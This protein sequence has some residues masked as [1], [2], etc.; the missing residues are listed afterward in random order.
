MKELWQDEIDHAEP[1]PSDF[2]TKKEWNEFCKVY[3]SKSS[4]RHKQK[5]EADKQ[6]AVDLEIQRIADRCGVPMSIDRL[7]DNADSWL[8]DEPWR[9]W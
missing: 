2:K 3:Y 9:R 4:K 1:C 8:D 7:F 5:R 6:R